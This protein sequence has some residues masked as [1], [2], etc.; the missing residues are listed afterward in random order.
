MTILHFAFYIIHFA[1]AATALADAPLAVPVTGD[2][3]RAE[4]SAVDAGWQLTC[5]IGPRQLAMPAAD[6][7]CW[8][9]CPEQ[10]R[11]GGLVLADGSLLMA[12]AV[13]ADGQQLTAD[14]E[15]FGI[16]K[17]P[18]EV[19][20]GVVFHVSS[21]QTD[22]DKLLDRL[23]RA[24]SPLPQTGEGQRARRSFCYKRRRAKRLAHGH[25]RRHREA[26][27]RRGAGRVKPAPGGIFNPALTQTGRLIVAGLWA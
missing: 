3:F 17:L 4:L 11:A 10:G 18:L 21:N 16:V 15:L 26:P 6:L 19:V 24:N 13:A 7:V 12:E 1:L 20:S 14:S 27:D 2:P 22:R 9:Q 8:G 25:R 5:R 23:A